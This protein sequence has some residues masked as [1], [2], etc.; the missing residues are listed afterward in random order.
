MSLALAVAGVAAF[1]VAY[2][3]E[4]AGA[5]IIVYLACLFRLAWVPS[6]LP[7]IR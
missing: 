3:C 7:Q 6:A 5:V 2:E 1:H 4:A